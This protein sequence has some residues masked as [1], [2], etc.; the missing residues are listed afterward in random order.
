M[1]WKRWRMPQPHTASF[2]TK[3]GVWAWVTLLDNGL[4]SPNLTHTYTHNTTQLLLLLLPNI[5]L[6]FF[7]C[8]FFLLS[9]LYSLH[10]ALGL[11]FST[12]CCCPIGVVVCLGDVCRP[13]HLCLSCPVWL[14]LKTEANFSREASTMAIVSESVLHNYRDDLTAWKKCCHCTYDICFREPKMYF[15]YCI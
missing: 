6:L 2:K 11:I 5:W 10:P 7:H 1:D 13:C 8:P 12:A 4:L 14:C 3:L 15:L 9:S